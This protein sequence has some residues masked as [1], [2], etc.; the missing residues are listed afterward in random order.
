MISDTEN[1]WKLSIYAISVWGIEI[2]YFRK[3]PVC[4][5]TVIHNCIWELIYLICLQYEF[6]NVGALRLKSVYTFNRCIYGAMCFSWVQSQ[7][8]LHREFQATLG[9]VDIPCLEKMRTER[10]RKKERGG[11]ET[12]RWEFPDSGFVNI[13]PLMFGHSHM[14]IKRND[15][16][17][18]LYFNGII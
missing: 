16:N 6:H 7:F 17:T 5:V 1:I 15:N 3:R 11:E 10:E 9:H 4:M 14:N 12:H 8:G 13:Y 2:N 18:S